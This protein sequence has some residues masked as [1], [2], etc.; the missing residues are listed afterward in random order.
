MKNKNT[1]IIIIVL[2]LV[3]G[4][5]FWKNGHNYNQITNP[6]NNFNTLPALGCYLEPYQDKKLG[7]SMF[8]N[9]CSI[10][11]DMIFN[12]EAIKVFTKPANQAIQDAIKIQF[13][14]NLPSTFSKTC[15]VVKDTTDASNNTNIERYIIEPNAARK[16]EIGKENEGYVPDY[17]ECDKYAVNGFEA[18][19]QYQPTELKTKFMHIDIGQNL[20]NFDPDSIKFNN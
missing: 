4:I 6:K 20:P 15:V 11:G 7:I 1:L 5:V 8:V 2:V 3:V 12:D 10:N 14:D 13:I 18:Y 16:A 19:F 9:S 17:S